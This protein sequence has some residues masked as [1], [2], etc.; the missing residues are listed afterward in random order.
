[1]KLL[2]YSVPQGQDAQ[3]RWRKERM[4]QGLEKKTQERNLY[5]AASVFRP[6]FQS[7]WPGFFFRSA[8]NRDEVHC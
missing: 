5:L 6:V 7:I 2:Q 3:M 8:T 4:K 1:M